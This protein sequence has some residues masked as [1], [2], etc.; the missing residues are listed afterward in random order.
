MPH[1]VWELVIQDMFERN[2]TG[3]AKYNRYLLT[4]C[5]DN[6]LQHAYEEALDLAVYLK[7]EICKQ[8]SNKQMCLE[9]AYEHVA[10]YEDKH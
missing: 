1:K 4:N 6:T 7:T 2:E 10:R 8:Q 3:A 9:E 5:P